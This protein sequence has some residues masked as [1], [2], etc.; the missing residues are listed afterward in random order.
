MKE[1]LKSLA[2]NI[3]DD[4][5]NKV[6][7]IYIR[8]VTNKED[9]YALANYIKATGIEVKV[10]YIHGT[11][12]IRKVSNIGRVLSPEERVLFGAPIEY[13]ISTVGCDYGVFQNG[14]LIRGLVFSTEMRAEMVCDILI[15]DCK[16]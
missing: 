4:T 1:Y 14:D 6:S 12:I 10:L 5:E 2:D 8:E 16:G 3:L 7:A 15:E 9:V 13:A 11:Y